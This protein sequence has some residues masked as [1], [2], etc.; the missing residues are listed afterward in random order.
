MSTVDRLYRR[1]LMMV[2]PVKIT[3]T[4]DTGPVHKV[5][6]RMPGTAEILD[7]CPV[8]QHY[9]FASHAMVDTDAT[10]IFIGGDRTQAAIVGHNN[11]QFRFRNQKSGEVVIY[12]DEGDF[13]QLQRGR[14]V[15]IKCGTRVHIECPLVEMTGDLHV[16]GAII[17]GYGGSSQVG[18][19][20]HTHGQPADSHPD[21]EAE[22]HAPTKGT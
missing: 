13:V 6:M 5:Q 20:T 3:A 4:D 1:I 9:G 18:L 21:A 11:Q 22:T 10:A 7:N 14:I 16:N 8:I 12:T 2:A 19:Q 17:S 15:Y